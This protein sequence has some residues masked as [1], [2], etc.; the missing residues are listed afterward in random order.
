MS[1][2]DANAFVPNLLKGLLIKCMFA[3]A[4]VVLAVVVTFQWRGY[5]GQSQMMQQ[6]IFD[7]ADSAGVL[8][9]QQLGG[10]IKFGNTNAIGEAATT[11]YGS[12]GESFVGAI[13]TNHTGDAIYQ[14]ET[15]EFDVAALT[16]V[17][18]KALE[19]GQVVVDVKQNIVAHPALFGTAGEDGTVPVAG[20]IVAQ[21]SL[22]SVQAE[23]AATQLQALLVGGAV[24]VVA[25]AVLGYFLFSA[26][27][28]PINV[29]GS[30]MGHIAE[31]RYDRDM[32]FTQRADEIGVVSRRLANFRDS[33]AEGRAAELDAAFKSAAFMGSAAAMLLVDRD[34]RV[35]VLNDACTELFDTLGGTLKT[36]WSGD[37]AWVGRDLADMADLAPTVAAIK[38]HGPDALPVSLIAKIGDS[39]LRIKVNGAQDAAGQ[40]IGAVIEWTDR[41]ESQHNAAVLRGIDDNQLR[42]EFSASGVCEFANDRTIETFGF[43]NTN[44]KTVRL[45][46]LFRPDLEDPRMDDDLLVAMKEGKD[47]SG[48]FYAH[49]TAGIELVLSGTFVTLREK[50]GSF[51]RC[52]F[53]GVDETAKAAEMKE[54]R[55]EQDRI[56]AEQKGV[57]G[58]LGGALQALAKGDLTTAI[59]QDFSRDYAQVKLDF[60]EAVA[61][62]HDAMDVVM[63]ISSSIRNEATGITSAADELAQQTEKQAATLEQTATA[64][65]QLTKAVDLTAESAK[66]ARTTSATAQSNAEQGGDVARQ[67]VVAMDK[68]KNSSQEISKITTVIDDI[69]FQTNLL[70]LNA[71]VEAARAGEAGRGFAVVATEVRAL[72]QRSSEAAREINELITSSGEQVREGV[73]LVDRTGQA[74]SAIVKS[75]SDISDRVSGIA[76]SAEEQSSGLSEINAAMS[77]LDRVTQQNAAMFEETTAASHALTS[78]SEELARAVG[79]FELSATDE[80]PAQK[81][82][83][84][85]AKAKDG[86]PSPTKSTKPA[87]PVVPTVP[88]PAFD[89]NAAVQIAPVTDA[90]VDDWEEF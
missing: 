68:I 16:A 61:A 80:A 43:E 73:E 63:R 54:V 79:R 75:I 47:L 53:L 44:L 3:T 64:L 42:I 26:I 20:V 15:G 9:A 39:R 37:G 2:K 83:P 4:I 48:L 78:E 49:N 90:D 28:R 88:Q 72:A 31:Q 27:V 69:A 24:F 87:T 46:E 14:T 86:A 82:A 55:A 57:V 36:R 60:N 74:L 50:D 59:E 7:K 6:V 35:T 8:L 38:E 12:L 10:A 56:A 21:L 34:F 89:G 52:I 22:A 45:N 18:A 19:T 29:I 1:A 32:P 11:T 85:A 76:N 71:G 25:L 81:P 23:L 77:E 65:D 5:V 30:E 33:L 58:A 66:A 70:A 41:T 17:A 51:E 40:F 67:T 84:Q 62:L 13:V